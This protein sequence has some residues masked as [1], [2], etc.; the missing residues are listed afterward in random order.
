MNIHDL[1]LKRIEAIE[2]Y[3]DQVIKQLVHVPTGMNEDLLAGIFD[4]TVHPFQLRVDELT[5]EIGA[6]LQSVLLS[7]VI[8]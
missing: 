8:P 7:P 6:H 4:H 2:S 3:V 5:P 1:R